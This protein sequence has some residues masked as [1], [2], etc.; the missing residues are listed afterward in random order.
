MKPEKFEDLS[1][2][3]QESIDA[4]LD[5]TI[6]PEAFESLQDRMAKCLSLRR[7]VRRYQAV[8]HSLQTLS[9]EEDPAAGL[10]L[11]EDR[12]TNQRADKKIVSFP[13]SKS[14]LP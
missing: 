11:N 3:D 5:G 9:D 7:I 2:E 1:P 13:V 8:A 12:P 10:W 4:Y 6:E 14:V